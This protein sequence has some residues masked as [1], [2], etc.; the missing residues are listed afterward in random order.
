MASIAAGFGVPHTP[1][2]PARA[3]G[4]GP[5]CEEARLY[6]EVEQHLDAIHPDIIVMF[7]NDH[8]NTFFFDNFPLFAIGV[9]TQTSGP[10]DETPMP[11]Y[12]VPLHEP[13]ADHLRASA[14]R[15][16]FDMAVTQEFSL[17][18]AFMVPW[19]FLNAKRRTPLIPVF[20]HGFSDPLPNAWRAWEL[21]QMLGR[22][23]RDYPG[24]ERI[25]VIGSGSFSLEIGGPLAP[26]GERSGTPDKAWAA[27]IE[28]CLVNADIE[29]LI[30]AATCERMQRAG[31]AAG[32]LLNWIAMLGMISP[33]INAVPRPLSLKPQIDHGHAFGIWRLE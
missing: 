27:Q 25:A 9:A 18:H 17:D 12:D 33:D 19:H 30:E 15:N 32:E 28:R 26:A 16:D 24:A 11:A 21:G 20:I 7:S 1:A 23:A 4:Q 14:I 5:E 22:A 8:F 6:K 3:A 2:F 10:N 13:L 31:N 29:D